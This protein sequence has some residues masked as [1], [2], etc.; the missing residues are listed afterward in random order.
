LYLDLSA[1]ETGVYLLQTPY[2]AVKIYKQ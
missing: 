1:L 2:T